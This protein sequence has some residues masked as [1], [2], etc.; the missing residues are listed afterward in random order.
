MG[1]PVACSY[2]T[3]TFGHF[4]NCMLLPSFR[5]NLIY[6]CRYI[7]NIFGIWLPPTTNRHN[8]WTAF[9]NTLNNWSTLQWEVVEPTT[10]TH[11]LDLNITIQ[12]S[13]LK[14]STYQKPLNLYL[15][16]PPLSAHPYSWFKGLIKGGLHRY[17]RQN[18]PSDFQALT[19]KFLERLMARGHSLE[20]LHPIFIQAATT[21]DSIIIPLSPADSGNTLFIPWTHHPSGLQRSDIHRIY[22][23]T[24]QPCDI[25]D[26]MVVTLSRPKNS[27]NI[28]TKAA[29]TLPEGTS[30]QDYIS[31]LS[32]N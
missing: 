19:T 4:E 16:I 15:Y 32:Y 24:L 18:S 23:Q 17:W 30:T 22:N 21:L 11:F 6:Y 13:S 2:A 8:T 9:K 26:R 27:C 31:N 29:P 28:L 12:D 20:N 1:T 3:V 25:Q 10:T 14:F 5:G 7:D